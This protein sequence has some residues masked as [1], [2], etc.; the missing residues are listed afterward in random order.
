MGMDPK[1]LL[2]AS[3]RPPNGQVDEFINDEDQEITVGGVLYGVIINEDSYPGGIYPEEGYFCIYEYLTS[4]WGD[5][6]E[7]HSALAKIDEFKSIVE[8][9]CQMHNCTYKFYLAASFS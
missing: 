3:I 4:G 9:Y 5:T 7:L 2:V 6:T 1:T 8:D